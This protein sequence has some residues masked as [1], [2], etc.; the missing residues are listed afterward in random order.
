ME[1]VPFPPYAGNIIPLLRRLI[2]MRAKQHQFCRSCCS[3]KLSIDWPRHHRYVLELEGLV[4]KSYRCGAIVPAVLPYPDHPDPNDSRYTSLGMLPCELQ[5]CIL[6]EI[7]DV[8]S[9]VSPQRVCKIWYDMLTGRHRKQNIAIDLTNLLS[10]GSND[11]EQQYR[12]THLLNVLDNAVKTATQSLTLMNGDLSP[13]LELYV[14]QFLSLKVTRLRMIVLKN[15]WCFDALAEKKANQALK[16][17]NLRHLTQV[18]QVLHLRDV[19]F[20]ALLETITGLCGMPADL[21]QD[22]DVFVKKVALQSTL[23]ETDRLR[24]FLMAL[25]A[26]C[27]ELSVC[28]SEEVDRACHAKIKQSKMSFLMPKLLNE[29]VTGHPQPPLCSLAAQVFRYQY[30]IA[31]PVSS[32]SRRNRP[33][34]HVPSHMNGAAINQH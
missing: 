18:C 4:R 16:W 26:S 21:R 3:H 31:K 34:S 19:T 22:V 30:P 5:E 17:A 13:D 32:S 2:I 10:D 15:V 8:H 27:P 33:M 7:P 20:P 23:S 25:N 9:I 24:Q 12:R 14:Y 28:D 6:L 1:K 11:H 29:L